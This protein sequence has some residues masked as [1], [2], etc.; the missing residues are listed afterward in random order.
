MRIGDASARLTS[1]APISLEGQDAGAFT[2]TKTAVCFGPTTTDP[3]SVTVRATDEH[4]GHRAIPVVVNLTDRDEIP[5]QASNFPD[6]TNTTTTDP[7]AENPPAGSDASTGPDG[8]T[9]TDSNAENPP[10]G[11]DAS[12]DPDGPRA[13]ASEGASH[14]FTDVLRSSFAHDAVACI[15][16]LGIT[17]GATATTYGPA[18]NVTRAQMAVFL[19]RLHTAVTGTSAPVVDPHPFTD[20]ADSFA[21]NHIARIYGLG[22]TVGATATTYGPAANVTRAQMAVFLSRLHTAVTGTSAPVVDPLPFTDTADSFARN[23]IARIYGLGITAGATATTYGPAANV[24]RAQMAVFLSR[25]H[26]AVTADTAN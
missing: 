16:G 4:G 25:L 8:P 21:R 22:I 7:N 20:T 3:N 24:T 14:P 18:A 13:C 1:R 5:T 12:T 2:T 15:Y 11:S 26:T 23:H 9:T 19:S 6:P 17:V 10:A